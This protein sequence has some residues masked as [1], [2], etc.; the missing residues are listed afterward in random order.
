MHVAY[1][2]PDTASDAVFLTSGAWEVDK[3]NRVDLARGLM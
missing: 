2:S 1:F 3:I